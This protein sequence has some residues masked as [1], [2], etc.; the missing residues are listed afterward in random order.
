MGLFGGL[1][2]KPLLAVLTATLTVVAVA[3]SGGDDPSAT[4]K[5]T[6]TPR[7]P[8]ATAPAPTAIPTASGPTA[9]VPAGSTATAVPVAT[10]TAVPS[11]AVNLDYG[12]VEE[13]LEN[14]SY[15]PAWGIPKY[16]GVVKYRTTWPQTSNCPACNSTYRHLYVQPLYNLLVR[17]DPWE[18]FEGAVHP[19]L[20][21]SWEISSDGLSYTFQ[22]REGAMFRDAIP[23]D[24][25]HGI[26]DM[27][28]RGT[29]FTCEDAK[30][31]VDFWGTEDWIAE[32][33]SGANGAL[34]DNISSTS[35][36]DGP[37]GYTFVI[38]LASLNFVTFA[39]I[40]V[41]ALTMMDKDWLEWL[42]ADHAKEVRRQNWYLNM[43]TG[44]FVEEDIQQDIVTKMRRNPTY[45]REGL[46]FADGVDVH[47]IRDFATAFTSWASG[48]IDI[49]GQGSGSLQ[50]GQVIQA[51]RDFSDKPI[52]PFFHPGGMGVVYNVSRPPFDNQK[53]RQAANMV[54]DRQEWQVLKQSGRYEGA[55]IGGIWK[56]GDF[57]GNTVEEVNTW[58]GYRQPKDEDVAEA[59]RLLDEVYGPGQRPSNT[60]L[61]RTDQNYVAFCLY[62]ANKWDETLG[63]DTELNILEGVVQ[64]ELSLAG[65]FDS[66]A[67]WPAGWVWIY[68][69]SYKY[70]FFH[71][72]R[73]GFAT[74][75]H[76]LDPAQQSH[77]DE[78]IDQVDR[79]L[80]VTKRQVLSREIERILVTEAVFGSTIEYSK[81]FYGSQPW[82]KGV[83]FPN[84]GSYSVHAW[85]HERYWK[86]Q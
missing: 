61:T 3:C 38:E 53:V 85:I 34:F 86:D 80:D 66:L 35:C 75:R 59:I 49:L 1:R 18:G 17:Q 67:G 37:D 41:P 42:V 22:L 76:G 63:M 77:I 40:T 4:T 58:P 8:T 30:A 65:Q 31:S 13:L 51:D 10:A 73:P 70:E 9:T 20:A 33:N 45:W 43:G 24:E 11:T 74:Y 54:L 16:G 64:T 72:A 25:A 27:P 23:Q 55:G 46:P 19:D 62:V 84:Y 68:D 2:I 15:D 12:T 79:E 83:L 56:T 14:P 47:V 6:S 44:A 32:R 29:E 39:S 78:L 26:G 50:P 82:M 7:T 69:P 52:F 21:K 28:G 36:P 48:Q 5:P 81:L 57:Y 60:C 71:S